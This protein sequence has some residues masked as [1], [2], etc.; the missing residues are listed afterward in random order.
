[1]SPAR[2]LVLESDAVAL[3]TIE[4]ALRT[5]GF[6]VDA[7]SDRVAAR[8]YLSAARDQYHVALVASR[9][10]SGDEV[11]GPGFVREIRGHSARCVAVLMISLGDSALCD[12]HAF[13]R[14]PVDPAL[15]PA[16]IVAAAAEHAGIA[17]GDPAATM[18]QTVAAC[19]TPPK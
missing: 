15:L 18:R 13:V 5:V 7:A 4:R 6:A 3:S 19:A 9:L 14:K 2:V 11:S 10:G 1:M 16:Q 17:I 12:G 8:G